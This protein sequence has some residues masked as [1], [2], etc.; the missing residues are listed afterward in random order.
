M[1]AVRRDAWGRSRPDYAGGIRWHQ[2][3]ALCYSVVFS[4]AAAHLMQFARA[5]YNN[6]ISVICVICLYFFYLAFVFF[7]FSGLSATHFKFACRPVRP[8]LAALVVRGYERSRLRRRPVAVLKGLLVQVQFPERRRFTSARAR[9]AQYDVLVSIVVRAKY[10]DSYSCLSD[11][12][13][14]CFLFASSSFFFVGYTP[15]D[16]KYAFTLLFCRELLP[17]SALEPTETGP[18]HSRPVWPFA[19][20]H[21]GS[22]G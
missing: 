11:V 10:S 19:E 9:G 13:F 20:R 16:T 15:T 14:F 2:C 12:S 17:K 18:S 21:R 1:S 3:A 22:G 5:C 8:S 7:S 6:L 4:E